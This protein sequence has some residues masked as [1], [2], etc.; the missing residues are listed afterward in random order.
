[1][2]TTHQEWPPTRL[3]VAD[4]VRELFTSKP[5]SRETMVATARK[6]GARREVVEVL[7]NLPERRFA[8]LR[9]IWSAMP[10]MDVH[11]AVTKP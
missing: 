8:N 4:S 3:E 6:N 9:L 2:S 5:V 11:P 10:T 1:L 7:E